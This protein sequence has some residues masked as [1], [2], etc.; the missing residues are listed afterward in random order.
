MIQGILLLCIYPHSLVE[1]RSSS[2]HRALIIL[3]GL[4]KIILYSTSNN[5]DG[6]RDQS[7]IIGMGGQKGM[8]TVMPVFGLDIENIMVMIVSMLV[9]WKEVRSLDCEDNGDPFIDSQ[10]F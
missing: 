5:V 9:L 1:E 4:M 2:C 7:H 3:L 8:I 6:S 10:S